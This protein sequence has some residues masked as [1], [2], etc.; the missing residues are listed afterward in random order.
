MASDPRNRTSRNVF[1]FCADADSL[2]LQDFEPSLN[3]VL[4][5]RPNQAYLGQIG[6]WAGARR[7]R[8]PDV[9]D[10][11]GSKLSLLVRL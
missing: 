11:I 7:V 6:R 3:K 4:V 1:R 9:A 5:L 8:A 10:E 2:R